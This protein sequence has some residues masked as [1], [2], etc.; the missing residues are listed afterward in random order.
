MPRSNMRLSDELKTAVKFAAS[1]REMSISDYVMYA[2]NRY[3]ESAEPTDDFG[4]ERLHFREAAYESIMY[5][6]GQIAIRRW[7]SDGRKRTDVVR[8]ALVEATRRDGKPRD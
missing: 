3:G 2:V 6:A 7:G 1:S 4:D 8:A 5:H